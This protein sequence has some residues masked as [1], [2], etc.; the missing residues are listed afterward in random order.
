MLMIFLV[1]CISMVCFIAVA[2]CLLAEGFGVVAESSI[3]LLSTAYFVL[4]FTTTF[5]SGQRLFLVMAFSVA[6]HFKQHSSLTYQNPS[7]FYR[8]TD[9]RQPEL[10][11]YGNWL[12]FATPDNKTT[13]Q[14]DN[15]Q[16]G[17]HL[18]TCCLVVSQSAERQRSIR[19]SHSQTC[20]LVVLQSAKRQRNS[21]YYNITF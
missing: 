14:R 3:L 15:Q 8:T 4:L 10:R 6:V 12:R 7:F 11:N 18:Q 13:S 20:S 17:S 19:G 9:W 16:C 1:I 5:H 21:K 2:C